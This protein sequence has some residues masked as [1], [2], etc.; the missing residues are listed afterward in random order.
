MVEITMRPYSEGG[1]M[2]RALQLDQVDLVG[3]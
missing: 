1:V 3:R 2:N